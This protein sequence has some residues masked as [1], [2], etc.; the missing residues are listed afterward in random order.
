[1]KVH[2]TPMRERGK[3][4]DKRKIESAEPVTGDLT[5]TQG[6]SVQ[7]GRMTKIAAFQQSGAADE[8]PLP[9]LHDVELSWMGPNGFVLTGI[10]F[11]GEVAY[12]QSWWCRPL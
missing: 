12:G 2:A 10:E 8:Q 7:Y 9:P 3:Q 6:Q 5:I 1:M 4:R 11:I